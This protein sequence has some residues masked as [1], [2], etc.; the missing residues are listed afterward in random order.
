[1]E[2]RGW[3]SKRKLCV[4]TRAGTWWS[5]AVLLG[6]SL[7]L[8]LP[9]NMTS[10]RHR[11]TTARFIKEIWSSWNASAELL[12]FS[13]KKGC[14]KR[15]E[16]EHFIIYLIATPTPKQII[17]FAVIIPAKISLCMKSS[18][19]SESWQIKEVLIAEKDLGV[20]VDEK[21]NKSQQ[22]G[23]TAQKPTHILGCI[24]RSVA[25]RSREVILPLYS[26]LGRPHL[27]Y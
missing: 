8:S 24:K 1:M 11:T 17:D 6:G 18:N 21:L 9:G 23:L 10:W 22:C 26:T 14:S 4:E 16:D 5:W 12:W 20:L 2:M 15:K 7:I 19:L 13:K 25:S 3:G 27:E